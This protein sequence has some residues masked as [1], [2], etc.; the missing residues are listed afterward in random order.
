MSFCSAI[1][2]RVLEAKGFSIAV[3][4]QHDWKSTLDGLIELV[5]Y[6]KINNLNPEQVH[7]F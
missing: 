7:D 3:I 2:G 5:L 1:I 6:L 4:P